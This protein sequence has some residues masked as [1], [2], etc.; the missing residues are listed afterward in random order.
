MHLAKT[1]QNTDFFIWGLSTKQ[2]L[3]RATSDIEI[4][5]G[6]RSNSLARLNKSGHPMLSRPIIVL[7]STQKLFPYHSKGIDASLFPHYK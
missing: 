1:R 2:L 5:S 6:E 3:D 4:Y 7:S